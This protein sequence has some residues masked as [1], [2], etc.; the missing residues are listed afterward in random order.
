[1]DNK[2]PHCGQPMPKSSSFCMHCMQI[3]YEKD[4]QLQQNKKSNL[5]AII[6]C[7]LAIIVLLSG[8]F[9]IVTIKHKRAVKQTSVKASISTT[10]PDTQA[11][12]Q[13]ATQTTTSATK[14]QTPKKQKPKKKVTTSPPTTIIEEIIYE[15]AP[16]TTKAPPT[17][18][19][20]KVV[21]NGSM[22]SDY[23]NS[24]QDSSYTIPYSV[25]S[26]SADAFHGNTYLHSLKFSK[27]VNVS[28]N[29][30]NLFASL[31][32]LEKIYIYTGTS[33]DTQ[34]MQYFDGEIIYYYD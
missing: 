23:P 26:I 13:K 12:I 30:S 8:I 34:G 11:T 28:C 14:K 19:S 29:W 32:N 33:A 4:F 22:L 1:M 25:T 15:T 9:A 6:I 20:N 7:I 2:C 3:T 17:T 16:Q 31:P 21:I 27:R 10:K 5:S 18:A 24:K